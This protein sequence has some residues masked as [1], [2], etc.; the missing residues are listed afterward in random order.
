MTHAVQDNDGDDLDQKHV[1]EAEAEEVEGFQSCANVDD[2]GDEGEHDTAAAESKN[3]N[4]I[5]ATEPTLGQEDDCDIDED[6]E[7]DENSDE[8]DED[9]NDDTDSDFK[10]FAIS[11]ACAALR[12][13][14]KFKA[15]QN[16][17]PL[18]ADLR[19]VLGHL[20]G[21]K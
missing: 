16:T 21:L 13:R 4:D 19:V 20:L 1:F 11:E 15:S 18:C 3:Q 9:M 12:N 5:A 14:R 6:D 7:A 10:R 8:D 2:Y 17:C